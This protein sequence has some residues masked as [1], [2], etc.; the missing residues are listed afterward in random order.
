[1][2]D[3]PLYGEL[4]AQLL[5]GAQFLPDKPEEDVH[6]TLHALWHTATG[7]P[8]SSE[9]ALTLPLAQP[10][11]NQEAALRELVRRRIDGMPLSHL[12][13]RQRFMGLEMLAG[14]QALVPRAETQLLARAA[15]E[16]AAAMPGPLTVVDVCTGSG[17]VALAIAHHVPA[18]RVYAADLSED[19]VALARR[20]AAHLD[21]ASRVE[22]R[23]GDLLAP[24]DTPEF[25]GRVHLLTC[26]PPYISSAKVKLMP[27][28]ISGH[29]P[30]LAFD[31]GPFG[32]SILMR[33]LND[34]PRFLH[35]GG[36]LV[37]EVGL[38]Q[39]P[40]MAKRLKNSAAFDDVQSHTDANGDIRAIAARRANS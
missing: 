15:I 38:G 39:G 23:A 17:N 19:A 25:M 8:C 32:V 13:G 35:A 21:L 11:G 4:S 30:S 6:S 24:F 3:S 14:P 29:E 18:A 37:F 20:N 33:L 2:K 26:N 22:F 16:L 27:G 34:A 9:R 1:M 31:G 10:D 40:A 5:S 12:T 28:E 7:N 36:W